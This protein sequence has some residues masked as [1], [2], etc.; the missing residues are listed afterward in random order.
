MNLAKL[1]KEGFDK[2]HEELGEKINAMEIE[3]EGVREDVGGI[4]SGVAAADTTEAAV[5][6]QCAKRNIVQFGPRLTAVSEVPI[7]RTR[8]ESDTPLGARF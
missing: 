2:I 1:I 7:L 4:I 3:P 5:D 6:S 8:A